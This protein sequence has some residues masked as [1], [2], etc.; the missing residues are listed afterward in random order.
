MKQIF[1]LPNLIESNPFPV[2]KTDDVILTAGDSDGRMSRVY[3]IIYE[4]EEG[5]GEKIRDDLSVSKQLKH[6]E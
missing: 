6:L 5:G 4:I 2:V 1:V 3:A